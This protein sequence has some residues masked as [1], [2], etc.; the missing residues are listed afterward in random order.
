MSIGASSS[1]LI[2]I[3][4]LSCDIITIKGDGYFTGLLIYWLTGFR[5]SIFCLIY[6]ISLNVI[7][8]Y[9]VFWQIS[10]QIIIILPYLIQVFSFELTY[11]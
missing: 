7:T 4:S 9:N 11:F 5:T 10:V 8:Y 2:E 3:R 6:I 1:N